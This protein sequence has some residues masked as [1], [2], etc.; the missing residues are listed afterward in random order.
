MRADADER[1]LG[2]RLPATAARESRWGSEATRLRAPETGRRTPRRSDSTARASR[3]VRRPRPGSRRSTRRRT[4]SPDRCGARH[5]RHPGPRVP[6]PRA[7]R[8]RTPA[9]P[10]GGPPPAPRPRPRAQRGRPAPRSPRRTLRPASPKRPRRSR[11]GWRRSP[12]P[13]AG[14]PPAG[15][16][17]GP[18][19]LLRGS[20]QAARGSRARAGASG[21]EPS[22]GLEHREGRGRHQR[23]QSPTTATSQSPAASACEASF[24]AAIPE[25]A[26]ASTAKCPPQVS[27]A[28]ARRPGADARRRRQRVGSDGRRLGQQGPLHGRQS[29]IVRTRLQRLRERRK[30]LAGAEAQGV[31]DR[32]I[33]AE[34]GRAQVNSAALPGSVL[35]GVAGL[36]QRGGEHLEEDLLHPVQSRGLRRRE[37]E[38][39]PVELAGLHEPRR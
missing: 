6:R 18:R 12:A 14:H 20:F 30:Q 8:C 21:R 32:R 37:A 24:S 25:A 1:P 29:R 23:R 13:R 7:G 2:E 3:P 35:G 10:G 5:R 16:G 39:A 22:A 17:P 34:P 11:G 15:A 9:P 26:P 19:R 27:N 33:H 36:G 28:P 31:I 4:R 38:Q